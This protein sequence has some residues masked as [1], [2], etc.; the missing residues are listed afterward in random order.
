MAA[1]IFDWATLQINEYTSRSRAVGW[2]T[3]EDIVEDKK[4][5]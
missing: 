3:S 2:L 1:H 4:I 5:H